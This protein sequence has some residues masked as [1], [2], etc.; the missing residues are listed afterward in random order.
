M[1]PQLTGHGALQS[2]RGTDDDRQA[3]LGELRDQRPLVAAGGLDND[4]HGIEGR[5]A[6]RE[7]PHQAMFSHRW[8]AV[9]CCSESAVVVRRGVV[10]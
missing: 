5:G 8:L 2:T 10:H 1:I 6:T 7:L 3:G 4:P 9:F